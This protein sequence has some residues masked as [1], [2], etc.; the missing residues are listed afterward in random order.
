MSSLLPFS[1]SEF[2]KKVSLDHVSGALV[3]TI[4]REHRRMHLQKIRT[5]I[6]GLNKTRKHLDF[7]QSASTNKDPRRHYKKLGAHF[8]EESYLVGYKHDGKEITN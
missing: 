8:I 3:P 4:S 1:Q 7:K 6:K 5:T 2:N